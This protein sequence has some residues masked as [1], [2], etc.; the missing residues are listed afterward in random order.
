[1]FTRCLTQCGNGPAHHQLTSCRPP[2]PHP[3]RCR[4]KQGCLRDTKRG[5]ADAPLSGAENATVVVHEAHAT[6]ADT[7]GLPSGGSGPGISPSPSTA[8][9]N[10]PSIVPC[11]C[12]Q[13][14]PATVTFMDRRRTLA[15]YPVTVQGSPHSRLAC[16]PSTKAST[17]VC[18]SWRRDSLAVIREGILAPARKM[19]RGAHGRGCPLRRLSISVPV[20]K[21]DVR[22]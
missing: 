5:F 21:V 18:P 20:N 19:G 16:A 14:S 7:S 4:R 10:P 13:L 15:G 3:A 1:M 17:L 2:P 22:I 6:D 8:F 11:L 9:D 12:T